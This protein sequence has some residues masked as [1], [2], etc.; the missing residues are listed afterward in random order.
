MRILT[1]LALL[2]SFSALAQTRVKENIKQQAIATS[3][4][5]ASAP[6]RVVR[7]VK[8]PVKSR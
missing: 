3:E 6:V 8:K 5:G 4:D 1:I 7:P 2:M